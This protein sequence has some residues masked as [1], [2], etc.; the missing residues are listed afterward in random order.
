MMAN[1][2]MIQSIVTSSNFFESCGT[3]ARKS[4]EML[5][6]LLILLK[7]ELRLS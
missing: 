2:V 6:E 7:H 5:P 4:R 3:C 1:D